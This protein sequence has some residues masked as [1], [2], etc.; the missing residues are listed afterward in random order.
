MD[1]RKRLE[2][3][4]MRIAEQDKV[5]EE[6]SE[7]LAKAWAAVERLQARLAGVDSRFA[8]L[9]DALPPPPITKPPHW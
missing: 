5:I 7:E 1:V 9:E 3:L 6:L 4:E 2:T 8:S